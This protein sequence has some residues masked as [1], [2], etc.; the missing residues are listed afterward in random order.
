MMYTNRL[1]FAPTTAGFILSSALIFAPSLQAAEFELGDSGAT[2]TINTTI[3]AGIKY[4]L[5]GYEWASDSDE[6]QNDGQKSFNK[7]VVSQVI[8]VTPEL[9]IKKD[10]VGAFFRATAYYDHF[11]MNDN[12][13]KWAENTARDKANGHLDE[14]GSFNGWSDEVKDN[15]GQGAKIQRAYLYGDWEFAGGQKLSVKVGE[16]AHDWGETIFY[17]GGLKDLNAYDAALN[18]LPG[19]KDDLLIG[20]GMLKADFAFN[21]QVSVGGYVQYDWEKSIS[22]GRGAFKGHETDVDI[23]V[24]G[25]DI[26]WK[27]ATPFGGADRLKQAGFETEGNLVKV[28]DTSRTGKASDSGQWGVNLTFSP[29]SMSNTEFTVYYA[30]NHSSIPVIDAQ[31]ENDATIVGTATTIAQNGGSPDSAS[32]A[33]SGLYLLNKATYASTAYGEDIKIWG[34]SFHTKVFGYTQI[35]GELTY[36][37]NM[38]VFV[39]HPD[40]LIA[41]ILKSSGHLLGVLSG[42]NGTASDISQ[43][44]I[45]KSYTIGDVYQ[46][47]I[48]KPVWDA[49]LSV[50]QPFGAVLGTDLMYVVGELAGQQV[51]GLENYDQF[52]AKGAPSWN[53]DANA[54]DTADQRLDR[55]SWGYNLL[56]GANWNDV[57]KPGVNVKSTVRFTHDVDGNSH[58]TGRFEAGEKKLNLGLTTSYEDISATLSWGGDASDM[59]DGVISAALS[60]TL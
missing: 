23:F 37:E 36:T 48:R 25:S 12:N 6:N 34:A 10:N 42:S 49:S 30:N 43:A 9:D 32:I 19:S 44:G 4:A 33:S 56:L 59:E 60:Y 31:I 38:P 14:T 54:S 20:Q 27:D 3:S 11:L 15:Q 55:F 52:T 22:N 29:E 58:R 24:P 17:G 53:G 5:K 45:G 2:A 26:A 46:N 13:N 8:K 40:D 39:D 41:N 21:E 7:G 1:Q 18:T 16:Q 28:A 51:S 57:Y 50:I 47:Y 35:A